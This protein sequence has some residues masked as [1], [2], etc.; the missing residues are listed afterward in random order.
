MAD[1]LDMPSEG[2]A[3]MAQS[4]RT[5]EF[6]D[7]SQLVVFRTPRFRNRL[8][9][10]RVNRHGGIDDTATMRVD[11]NLA[12]RWTNGSVVPLPLIEKDDKPIRRWLRENGHSLRP[13]AFLLYVR[14]GQAVRVADRPSDPEDDGYRVICEGDSPAMLVCVNTRDG[15]R[16][17]LL[18]VEDEEPTTY[19]AL[20]ACIAKEERAR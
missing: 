5:H 3:A 2:W 1:I 10:L 16:E 9:V 4:G 18:V 17:A 13:G 14:R 7:G 11:P 6:R 15:V 8:F 12:Y 20:L 19:D